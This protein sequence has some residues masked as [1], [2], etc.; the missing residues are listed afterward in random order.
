MDDRH[1]WV[2]SQIWKT[3]H[4][5]GPIAVPQTTKSREKIPNEHHSEPAPTSTPWLGWMVAGQKTV[6]CWVP[7]LH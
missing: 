2:K 6:F 1:F 5:M 4:C 3:E 7:V